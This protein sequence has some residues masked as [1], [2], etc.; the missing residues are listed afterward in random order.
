MKDV[1]SVEELR[2]GIFERLPNVASKDIL[3]QVLALLQTEEQDQN[4]WD[5][6]TEAQK[7]S[8][9]IGLADLKAGR[10]KSH[11]EVIKKYGM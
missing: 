6:L 5:D 9:G 2:A 8:I 4:W 7:A 3:Y 11:A 10:R 1:I